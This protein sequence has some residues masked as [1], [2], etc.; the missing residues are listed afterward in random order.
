ME[1]SP[2]FENTEMYTNPK[3][4]HL[5]RWQRPWTFT[6]TTDIG[7]L[8]FMTTEEGDLSH[9]ELAHNHANYR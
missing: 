4:I 1:K 6:Q 7:V 2:L 5:V 9:T 3:L 8:R